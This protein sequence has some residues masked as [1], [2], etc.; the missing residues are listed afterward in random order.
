VPGSAFADGRD[1][2]SQP[3]LTI[4]RVNVWNTVPRQS[5]ACQVPHGAAL[6]L[7]EARYVQDE[8]R[9][10]F[11]VDGDGCKGWLPESFISAASE[12]PIGDR[13]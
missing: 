11:L 3:P 4:M 5:V 1:Q 9:Y 10:Y 7:S 13:Q 12:P 2:E 6:S 8:E